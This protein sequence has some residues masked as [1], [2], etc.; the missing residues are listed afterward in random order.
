MGLHEIKTLLHR[1]KEA[2]SRFANYISR[3]GFV[4]MIYKELQKLN[5]KQIEPVK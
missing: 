2:V 4:P 3:G 1:A 5:K